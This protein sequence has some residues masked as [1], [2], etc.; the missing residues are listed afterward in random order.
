MIPS[1]QIPPDAHDLPAQSPF[2]AH[3]HRRSAEA[4]ADFD[5]LQEVV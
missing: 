4:S 5:T 2:V 3:T 1:M